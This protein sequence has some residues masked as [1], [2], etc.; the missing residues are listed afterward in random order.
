MK[1][2]LKNIEKNNKVS[3]AVKYNNEYY[4]ISGFAK[5]YSFGKYLKVVLKRSKSPLPKKAIVISIK[6]VFDLDKIKKIL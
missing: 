4:R 2:S 3:I 5:I 6:E 1:T